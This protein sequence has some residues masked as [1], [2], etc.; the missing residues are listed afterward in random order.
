M[1]LQV[2][3]DLL[4]VLAVS[5]HTNGQG[6][7]SE[8]QEESVHGSLDG[9]E[10]SHQLRCA[11]GDER[12]AQT[13]FL[14][15]CDPVIGVIGSGQSRELVSVCH[16]VEFAAV[17]DRAAN[18][19]VVSIHVF[20]RGMCDDIRA[21]LNGSAV[22]RGGKC[23][24][25]DQRNTMCMRCVCKTLDVKY[26]K[27]GIGDGLAKNSLGI[28]LESVL[29]F[30]V[31]AVGINE[32]EINAHLAH[33]YVEQIECA[34]VDGRSAYNVISA[35]CNI[36]DT[37]EVSSL[38]GRSQ[39]TGGTAFQGTDLSRDH[40]VGGILQT[41]I[42]I[43]GR[44]KIEQFS[45]IFAG[46]IFKS[47]ALNDRDHSGLSV[48]GRISGLNAHCF[49]FH[50]Q[51]P[52]ILGPLHFGPVSVL[53]LKRSC[54][55]WQILICAFQKSAAQYEQHCFAGICVP[56][57]NFD[58]CIGLS[59]QIEHGIIKQGSTVFGGNTW[60]RIIKYM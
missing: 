44:L 48:F 52:P 30:L 10:V 40:I 34:S 3:C 11:F 18:R 27:S 6:L 25:D 22:N 42:E 19:C 58:P 2:L 54:C 37:E 59:A 57:R 36:E 51:L 1:A 24:V 47:C 38:S 5:G 53:H 31:A 45:H 55:G 26:Y 12:T 41:C 49:S 15:V 46:V 39:H 7:Q 29:Q 17:D 56:V 43:T 9:T 60:H 4:R 35:S 8:I 16:P 14:G 50:F 32:S 21:P 20:G 28:R 13:E 23:V 33:G